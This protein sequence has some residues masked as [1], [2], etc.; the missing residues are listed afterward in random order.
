M[1]NLAV[2]YAKHCNRKTSPAC[3]W[4]ESCNFVMASTGYTYRDLSLVT[5]FQCCKYTQFRLNGGEA[6]SKIELLHGETVI[7]LPAATFQFRLPHKFKTL[8]LSHSDFPYTSIQHPR[9]NNLI[10]RCAHTQ[11][12]I[13]E[14]HVTSSVD[15]IENPAC[16]LH[17][18]SM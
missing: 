3:C 4:Y 16:G 12:S 1:H 14:D 10:A 8:H 6:T 5:C 17:P 2:R 15:P 18:S 9:N 7:S 13:W 11:H